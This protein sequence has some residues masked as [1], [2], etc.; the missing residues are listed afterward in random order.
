MVLGGT[1]K[2]KLCH[3]STSSMRMTV[4]YHRCLEKE[5]GLALIESKANVDTIGGLLN[6]NETIAR[7]D[8]VEP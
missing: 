2:G 5:R 6:G 4:C 1:V 8:R 7:W 3:G